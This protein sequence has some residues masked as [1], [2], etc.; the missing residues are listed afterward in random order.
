MQERRE[1][2]LDAAVNV[3]AKKGF[4]GA[5]VADIAEAAKVGKG[6]MYLYF[7]SKEEVFRAILLERSVLPH[8]AEMQVDYEAPLEETLTTLART[9]I[10]LLC[11]HLPIIRLVLTDGY[12][13]PDHAEQVYRDIVLKGNKLFADYLSAQS[14]AG[15]IRL[16]DNPLLTAYAFGGLLIDY[17][18]TQELL[19]GKKFTP[20]KVED[21]VREAVQ[22]FLKGV[23]P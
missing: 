19:G 9:Y 11:E 1:Q 15:R 22:V 16:L 7:K 3:F 5:N 23:Q 12:R 20:I 18:M 2:I 14:K 4:D 10:R 13:H 17:V 8:L 6:T 21:W